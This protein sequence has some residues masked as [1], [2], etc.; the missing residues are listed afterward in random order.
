M[1]VRQIC[2]FWV[3]KFSFRLRIVFSWAL[4]LVCF[5]LCLGRCGVRW[6][7]AKGPAS[8]TAFPFSVSFLLLV[9]LF[10]H[11]VCLALFW[12]LLH[13][14]HSWLLGF[15]CMFSGCLD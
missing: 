2:P 5:V 9:L 3:A 7:P 11:L 6:G 14:N 4:V 1:E 8:P 13:L 12:L 10:V 15:S